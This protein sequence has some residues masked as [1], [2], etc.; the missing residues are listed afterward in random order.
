[1][2]VWKGLMDGWLDGIIEMDGW[3]GWKNGWM[4]SMNG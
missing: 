4:D 1:M 2:D 3:M